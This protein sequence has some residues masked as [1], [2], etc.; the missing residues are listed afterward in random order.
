MN[1][2]F[3]SGGR[4]DF[5]RNGVLFMALADGRPV[6]CLVS[7]E[8]LRDHFDALGGADDH[9]HAFEVNQEAIC[10]V[11]ESKILR[12]YPEPVTLTSSDF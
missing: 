5:D 12:G 9:E 11:A 8:A 10:A 6:Q 3:A 1:I 7:E 2:H 4:F